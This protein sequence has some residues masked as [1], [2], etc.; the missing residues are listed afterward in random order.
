MGQTQHN[1]TYK[2]IF[3]ARYGSI[4]LHHFRIIEYVCRDHNIVVGGAR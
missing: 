4:V 1:G 3:L 2:N